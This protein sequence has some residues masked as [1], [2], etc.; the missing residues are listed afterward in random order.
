LFSFVYV[1]SRIARYITRLQSLFLYQFDPIRDYSLETIFY[2]LPKLSLIAEDE[3]LVSDWFIQISQQFHLTFPISVHNISIILQSCPAGIWKLTAAGKTE[4]T[5]TPKDEGSAT[6]QHKANPYPVVEATDDMEIRRS[7]KR[8]Q[9]IV[10]ASLIDKQ[11]N[12][13][14]L[15]RTGEI[16][17]VKE[18]VL[19]S[20]RVLEDQQFLNLSMTAHKWL[21]IKQVNADKK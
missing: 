18:L 20:I 4:T 6:I 17:G 1:S 13:G 3:Y 2:L 10:V 5:D 16:F 21:N 14:G 15:C 8:T 7:I 9:L 19:A 11:T 12:L